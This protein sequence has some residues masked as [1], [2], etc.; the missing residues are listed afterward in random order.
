VRESVCM[1]VTERETVCL[2]L[3]ERGER[4]S[5]CVCVCARHS[6]HQL[7]LYFKR[8]CLNNVKLMRLIISDIYH[9]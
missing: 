2:C 6:L 7:L 5:V 3:R 9:V 8:W 1:C 4:E